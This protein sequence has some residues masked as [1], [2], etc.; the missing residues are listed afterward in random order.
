MNFKTS[1][2][3]KRL[4]YQELEGNGSVVNKFHE[5]TNPEVQQIVAIPD[6][7]QH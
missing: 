7:G 4:G 5:I 3:N 1:C 6:T 2:I